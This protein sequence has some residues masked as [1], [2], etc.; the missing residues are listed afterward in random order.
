[1]EQLKRRDENME[2]EQTRLIDEAR[3][4][5]VKNAFRLGLEFMDRNRL[6]AAMTM[7]IFLVLSLLEMVP[8]LG[9]AAGIALGVFS[10]AVQIYVGRTFYD[11]PDI[12]AFVSGAESTDLKTFLTRYQGQAFG[13]W[14][15]WLALSFLFMLLFLVFFFASGVDLT[16]FEQADVQNEAQIYALLIAVLEAGLPVVLAGLVLSYVYPIAQGRVIRSEG[17]GEAFKAVFSIFTPTVWAAAMNKAYFTYVF[18]FSLALMGI[19]ALIMATMML[20]MLI[21]FLGAVLILV[22]TV[23]LIYAFMMVLGVANTIAKEIAEG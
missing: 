19:G 7:G 17:F 20:L 1:M 16:A 18:F 13:A 21:P 15:G 10:Q 14:L 8:V 23:F 3:H 12:G 4:E 6:L 5:P 11:A 2:T 22:W 9:M